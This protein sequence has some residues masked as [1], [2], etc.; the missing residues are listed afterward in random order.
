MDPVSKTKQNHV[1]WTLDWQVEMSVTE[2]STA[3][4]RSYKNTCILSSL[5]V[6]LVSYIVRPFITLNADMSH[7][8]VGEQISL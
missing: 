5:D 3:T 7:L 6:I 8:P 4:C 2:G 1:T